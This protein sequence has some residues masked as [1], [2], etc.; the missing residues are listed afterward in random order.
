MSSD[1]DA[2][3]FLGHAAYFAELLDEWA[4]DASPNERLYRL[5]AAV[6]QALCQGGS[7]DALARYFEYWLMRLEGV[8]PA[9]EVCP[10]CRRRTLPAGAV[11]VPADRAFVCEDCSAGGLRLS[12]DAMRFLRTGTAG[13]PADVAARGGPAGPLREIEQAHS[14]LIAMH[15]ERE[16]RSSRV[17]KELRPQS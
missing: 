12:A 9:L 11:F 1:G 10:R 16:L 6:S 4:P 2:A 8:Y 5:G 17:M 13:T 3:H 15:L 7:V 14:R